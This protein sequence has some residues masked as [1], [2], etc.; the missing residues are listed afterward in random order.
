[1]KKQ[2]PITHTKIVF[3]VKDEPILDS[4]QKEFKG[5]TYTIGC[6]KNG[7]YTM[8]QLNVDTIVEILEDDNVMLDG[9]ETQ[10]ESIMHY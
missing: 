7:K 3:L 5:R 1:M 4:I 2:Y 8:V 10:F 6:A 9:Y